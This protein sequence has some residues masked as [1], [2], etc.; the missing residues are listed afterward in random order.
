MRSESDSQGVVIPAFH[1]SLARNGILL[2]GSSETVSRHE[3][4]FETLD[5]GHRIFQKRDVPTP[6]LRLTGRDRARDGPRDGPRDGQGDRHDGQARRGPS[7]FGQSRLSNWASARVLER[8]APPF[9]IVTAGGEALHYSSN[10]ARYLEV[11]PG[12]PSQNILQMARPTLRAPLRAVLNEAA[13]D[14]RVAERSAL[15][16]PVADGVTRHVRLTVEPR[17]EAGAETSFLVVFVEA[18]GDDDTSGPAERTAVD[19]GG[20]RQLEAELRDTREQLQSITEEHDTALEELRSANEEMHSVN[21]EIQS[22][23]EELETSKEE[24][25]SINEELQT[26]NGQLASKVDELDHKNSDLQ[27]LFE[28]TQVATIFLDPYLVVCSFTPAIASLYNLIPSDQGRPLTDIVSRVRYSTLR[29]DCREVFRTLV[30]LER[31]VSRD[32]D[33]AHYLMRILPYRTPDSEV[34]GTIVTL[35]DVTSIVRAEQHQRLLVDELNH[36]VKNM[37][38]VVISIARQ[39]LRRAD[40]LEDFETS[41]MGR[42][43]ALSAAYSLLSLEGWQKVRLG[44]LLLEELRPFVSPNGANVHL[45]GPDVLLEPRAALS[46]GLAIHELTTNAVKHGALSAL[47][48]NVRIAWHVDGAADGEFLTLRWSEAGGPKVSPP[49]RRGFGMTLIERGL[50]QDMSA[51]VS[52]EFPPDGVTAVLRAPLSSRSKGEGVD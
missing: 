9:V 24:I 48:G 7:R 28:S 38:A 10:L 14:G 41:Y 23:N 33:E 37:L 51:E 25:Q 18:G 29:E 1:Y 31:R 13:Q 46:L 2:L 21:E 44:T 22:T 15:F 4:L 43:H 34:D 17:R 47:D 49:T 6:P 35:V 50:R 26:V 32:D 52:V 16:M 8:F 27:N 36:R 20:D 5:R 39:T 12:A 45:E 30:P 11:P 42:V 19:L 3:G 40:T